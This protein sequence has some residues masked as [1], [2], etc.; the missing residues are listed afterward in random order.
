M[1]QESSK[2]RK[3][4]FFNYGS[5]N[6]HELYNEL[7]NN[8]PKG[9][10]YNANN[11]LSF[12][13]NDVSGLK[14]IKIIN[15]LYNLFLSKFI[16]P[17]SLMKFLYR[18]RKI[19]REFD[20]VHSGETIFSQKFPWVISLQSANALAGHN[21]DML[22]KNKKNIE[23]AFSSDYCKKIMPF[24]EAAK[25]T[26]E[27][28]LDTSGFKHKIEVV[29][30]AT[31]VRS[32]KIKKI[33]KEIKLLC[34]GSKRLNNSDNFYIK[35]GGE[36]VEAFRVLNKKYSN[37]KLIIVAYV[38]EEIKNKLEGIGNFEIMN[39]ITRE[40]LSEI[41]HQ[42][43]IYLYPTFLMPGLAVVE[44]MGSGLPIITT[45]IPGNSEL[46]ENEKNGFVITCPYKDI[47]SKGGSVSIKDFDKFI[48]KMKRE[49]GDRLT[50]GIVEKVSELIDKPLLRKKMGDYSREKYLK[51]F[52]IESRNKHLKRIYDEIKI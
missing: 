41:Y 48:H 16:T 14:K 31:K 9:Y 17:N 44:A 35:G 42:C 11:R 49:N 12:S 30:F 46:V 33:S 4:Y 36:I 45:D 20:F 23:K 29:H 40:E 43:D 2:N 15:Y 27:V 50:N 39:N 47:Y 25:K 8:P 18:F 6:F 51:E 22:K 37:L 10:E 26:L 38:P 52:S 32:K 1:E 24:T 13:V 28:S 7:I 3:I 21:S 5:G 19:P 34:V